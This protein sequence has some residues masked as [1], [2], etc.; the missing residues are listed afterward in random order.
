MHSAITFL[1]SL[2]FVFL[3]KTTSSTKW[4]MGTILVSLLAT[5]FVIMVFGYLVMKFTSEGTLLYNLASRV[6]DKVAQWRERKA[7]H[8]L[9]RRGAEQPDPQADEESWYRNSDA[10]SQRSQSTS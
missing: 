1:I 7:G 6:C 3:Y 10:S 5:L 2:A 8:I 9:R 4:L